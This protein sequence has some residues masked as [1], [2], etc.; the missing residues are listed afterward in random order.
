MNFLNLISRGLAC[1]EIWQPR[2]TQHYIPTPSYEDEEAL[3]ER[4][5]QLAM[6]NIDKKLGIKIKISELEHV[7]LI[8]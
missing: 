3:T 7:P 4:I 2:S 1:R 6:K 8:N 5:V